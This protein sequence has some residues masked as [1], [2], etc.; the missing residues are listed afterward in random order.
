M[1]FHVPQN[2]DMEDKIVGPLTIK[3]FLI[4]VIGGSVT[5]LLFKGLAGRMGIFILT[6]G[7]IALLT[8]MLAFLK[9]QDR[10]FGEFLV[11]LIVYAFRPQ[12]RIWQ[13]EQEKKEQ[14]VRAEEVKKEKRGVAK[15][16]P[17]KQDLQNLSRLLDTPEA[18]NQVKN[19]PGAGDI[20]INKQSK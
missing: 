11:A 12:K 15:R 6:G 13:R 16:A 9:V 4:C 8:V 10:P 2:I 7:P 17:T 1:Q 19:G 3:Q 5:Y 18:N 20:N 14:V